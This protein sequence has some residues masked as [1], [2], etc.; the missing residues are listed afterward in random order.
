MRSVPA[1]SPARETPAAN[2]QL[3]TPNATP[4][5]S[6]PGARPGSRSTPVNIHLTGCHHSCAQHFVSEIG[7]LACKVQANEDDD[8]VEGYHILIGGGFGPNAAL[9]RELYRDVVAED[10]PRII[11]RILKAYLT[12][13]AS[14]EESFLVFSRRND[15]EVL[16]AMAEREPAV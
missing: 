1:W 7:L 6:Q 14:P 15:V 10:A 13:R 5:T 3:P 16:K 12:H 4:R 9:G 11:E 2:S 8:P